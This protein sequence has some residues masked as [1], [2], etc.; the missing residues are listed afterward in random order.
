M[1]FNL[2]SSYKDCFFIA[3]GCFILSLG[4]N[5]FLVPCRIS[6]GGIGAL[7][8][9]LL[10]IFKIPLSVTNLLMNLILFAF[11]YRFLGKN[12]LLKTVAG[13]IFLSF[14]LEFTSSFPGYT[15][16]FLLSAITGG[17][18]VG[19]GLG[20][21]VRREASTGGSDFLGLMLKK[22][23]PHIPTATLILFI[24]C[25]I[26][27]FSGLIFRSI[28]VTLYS[29]IAMYCAA[30]ITDAIITLG[31]SAKAIYIISAKSNEI[32]ERI[33]TDFDRG[34]TGIYSRGLYSGTD[35]MMLLCIVMPKEVPKLVRSV[36]ELDNNAFIVIF[37][38]REVLG[39]GF[40]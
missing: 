38:A 6:S 2:K 9:V 19:T 1:L 28:T 5:M 33:L 18:L 25:S 12:A 20:I 36:R 15:N 40:K 10:Y 22:K 23:F 26:I 3:V 11:G 16:D 32:S 21:V 7:G 4:M 24:D 37:D 30:K 39:K 8:T 13:V 35:R 31:R 29:A 17:F 34:I 27:I 14:F